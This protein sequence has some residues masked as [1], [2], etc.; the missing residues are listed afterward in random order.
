MSEKVF[1]DNVGR[2]NGFLGAGLSFSVAGGSRHGTP[3]QYQKPQDH[4]NGRHADQPLQP[5]LGSLFHNT[6]L[7]ERITHNKAVLREVCL[8]T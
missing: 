3:N 2:D 5:I 1:T 6:S 7:V 4:G 8:K